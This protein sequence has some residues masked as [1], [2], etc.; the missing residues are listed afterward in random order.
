MW[1]S[2][3]K[4]VA[5]SPGAA[6][7]SPEEAVHCNYYPFVSFLESEINRQACTRLIVGFRKAS[8]IVMTFIHSTTH[9]NANQPV[10]HCRGI[11]AIKART[12]RHALLAGPRRG[13]PAERETRTQDRLLIYPAGT[14]LTAYDVSRGRSAFHQTNA[15]FTFSFAWYPAETHASRQRG[16]AAQHARCHKRV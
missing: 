9:S 10:N 6:I 16:P 3:I 4:A 12:D 5:T 11:C 15:V 2:I 7:Y 1:F 14:S 13:D 8:S